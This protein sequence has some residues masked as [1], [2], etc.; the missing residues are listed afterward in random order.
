MFNSVTQVCTTVMS[1]CATI[2]AVSLALRPV[3]RV[4]SR[5]TILPANQHATRSRWHT[6][7]DEPEVLACRAL[8]GH[9]L[10]QSELQKKWK[11]RH[12][13]GTALP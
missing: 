3:L 9:P 7:E 8:H 1:I 10:P 2:T 4:G 6:H 12:W 13:S 11:W 5:H